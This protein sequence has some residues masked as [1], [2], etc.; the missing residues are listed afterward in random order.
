[1]THKKILTA[2]IVS[3][4]LLFSSLS[5]A[6]AHSGESF[7][8]ELTD[9]GFRPTAL[10]IRQGDTVTFQNAGKFPH[11][12]ASDIHPTHG[13][14]PEF[15]PKQE[16][17][18]EE[19]WDFRFEK[20]G[21]WKFHDH[22]YPDSTG[23]ITVEEDPDFQPQKAKSSPIKQFVE[24]VKT[25]LSNT[26]SSLK[27]NLDRLGFRIF[28][29]L[30]SAQLEK[31][32][33]L[34]VARNEDHLTYWLKVLGPEKVLGELLT[35]SGGGATIDCHQESHQ[36][37]RLS[38]ELFGAGTFSY[39]DASCHSGYYHGA[40]EGFLNEKGTTDLAG[41]IDKICKQFDTGFGNFECLHGVGHGVIAY[42]DYDLTAAIEICRQLNDGFAT[43]SCYGGVFMENIVTAQGLGAVPNHETKWVDKTDPQFPCNKIG[44]ENE[45][46]VQCYMMQTSWMLT[47]YNY[48]FDKVAG[49]C[50]SAVN[51]MESTCFRSFG[52]DSAGHTLRNPVKINELCEKVPKEKTYY[53]DCMSGAVNVIIEFWGPK[54]Q[55][56]AS[57]YCNLQ[58]P[59]YKQTCYS[60]LAT[61]L[62]DVFKLE[63]ERKPVCATFEKDYQYLCQPNSART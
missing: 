34:E 32:N 54:L 58:P 46:L 15:D 44:T 1:M 62:Q 61:R 19:S 9:K 13:I 55:D 18:P 4:V 40:M 5:T 24:S 59:G 7:D 8:V 60:L 25:A 30:L 35:D 10:T 36:I 49:G 43:S 27:L 53:N 47:L 3:F 33:M 20:A 57:Q 41:N 45:L 31:T 21:I 16:I 38:Y 29:K 2:I 52:R 42:E 12:P 37:G 28:P 11:W 22:M 14:Y 51:G 39:G 23:T 56:Q 50:L 17:K 26:L 6:S 48:N 63:E